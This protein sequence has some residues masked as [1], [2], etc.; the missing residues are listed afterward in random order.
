MRVHQ[1]SLFVPVPKKVITQLKIASE[2][3]FLLEVLPYGD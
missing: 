2:Y 3:R 1:I